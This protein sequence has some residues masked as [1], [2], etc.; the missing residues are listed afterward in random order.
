MSYVIAEP[1]IG[2]KNK[3]CVE[4]CPVDCFYNH[5]SRELNAKV[6]REPKK[7]G[8]HGMLII[9]PNE[10]IHCGACETEC[11]VEAIFEDESVPEKWKEYIEI[12]TKVAES[13]STE[14]LEKNRITSQD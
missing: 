9:N 10:C 14:D 1:C 7:A 12:N 5:P 13:Y 6:G 11:P 2:E 4:V 3:A 8:D